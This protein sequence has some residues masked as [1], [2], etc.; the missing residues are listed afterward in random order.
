MFLLD[1]RY[2]CGVGVGTSTAA[3]MFGGINGGSGN[4][5]ETESW[6]GSSWT[7]VNDLNTPRRDQSSL[8]IYTS[9]LCSGGNEAPPTTSALNESWNGSSWTEVNNLNTGALGRKGSGTTSD[10]LVFG[11]SPGLANTEDWDGNV[12]SERN[13]LNTGREKG[14][15]S[16][17]TGIT[18]ALFSGGSPDGS[19]VTAVTEEWSSVSN[20]TK[21][22]ST[23]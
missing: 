11:G 13:D 18:S 2:R 20:T 14:G 23:D 6:N 22:I 9:A 8:G 16:T 10:G 4:Q 3:L 21:T 12:F 5:G 15:P 1:V 17:V 7:E 19:A